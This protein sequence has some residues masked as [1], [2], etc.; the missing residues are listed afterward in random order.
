MITLR[1]ALEEF[2]DYGIVLC[3]V[4][5]RGRVAGWYE[6]VTKEVPAVE[7]L[8][9]E[10]IVARRAATPRPRLLTADNNLN[11]SIPDPSPPKYTLPAN[12]PI[13]VYAI[14]VVICG[15]EA[16]TCGGLV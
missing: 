10:I 4:K 5:R 3:G 8:G 13:H 6:A 11:P 2:Q 1:A 16:G 9:S 7:G 15:Q 12:R 14:E